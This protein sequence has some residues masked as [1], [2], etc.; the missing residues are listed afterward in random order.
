MRKGKYILVV[1]FIVATCLVQ[2]VPAQ[3]A[4]Y[5]PAHSVLSS[6]VWYKMAF[7]KEGVCKIGV[8]EVP[9]LS[10]VS[11]NS[12]GVYGNGGG[13][14]DQK[15]SPLRPNDLKQ[16]AVSVQDQNG[17]GKMDAGDCILFYAEGADE[18]VYNGTTGCM[19]HRRH[20]YDRYNYYYVTTSSRNAKYIAVGAALSE[21]TATISDYTSVAVHDN[22]L[23]NTNK[24]GQIWVG[25]KMS[26]TSPIC[27]I[28]MT[29]PQVSSGTPLRV[30]A[31]VASP[32]SSGSQFEFAYG[33]S[34]YTV[35]CS[36]N[37]PYVKFSRTYSTSSSNPTFDITYSSATSGATGYLDFIELNATSP[38]VF[39]SGQTDVYNLKHIGDGNA[40]RFGI[41][42]ATSA[43]R[44]WNVVHNDSVV[45]MSLARNGTSASFTDWTEDIGHYV[46]F[47]GSR[48][49][50]PVSINRI[51]NQDIHS[52]RGAELVI[53][54]HPTFVAQAREIA[55]LHLIYDGI[56]SY[57]VTPDLV[58]N[59]FSSGKQDP[60]AIRE[61]LRMLYKRSASGDGTTAPRYLL[62]L[63]CGTYDNKNL[64][65]YNLPQV[66]TCQ[67]EASFT[68]EG[69]SYCTDDLF[70][71]LDDGE[72]GFTS[73]SL[74]V[75]IGR[76]PAHNT[77]EA[78][79]LVEK[80]S[81]YLQRSD[82]PDASI[83]G[84]WRNYITLLADDADPSSPGDT[85]FASSSE[86]MAN[87]INAV[88]PH[89]NIDKIYADS[90]QQQSGAI[91]SF[92]PDVNNALRQ[93]MDY[94]CLLF[95]YIGHGSIEYIGTERYIEHS[96]ITNYSN[97]DQLSLFVT[98]TCSY[99]RFDKIDVASG[100]ELLLNADGGAVG[101][102]TASR[103]IGH[104]ERFNT[105]I[106]LNA[107]SPGNTIGDALRLAKNATSV[108]HSFVLLG[109][110]A[111]RLSVPENRVVVTEINGEAVADGVCDS[112][113]VLSVVTVKGMVVDAD[114]ERIET[115]D[116]VLYPTVFDRPVHTHTLANDN[117][118]TE[119]NFTQQNSIIYR[120]RET[121]RHGQF[122][123]SFIVP[124][125]VSSRYA[126]AKLSHFA[127]TSD[128]DCATG[129]Y[130]QLMLGGFNQDA[131]MTEC[132]PE[133]KLY[134]N[135]T[136]FHSGG[137]TD[138]NPTLFARLS[139][140]VGIN[141]VG[142]GI[143]HN[144]TAVIDGNA[145]SEITLNDFYETDLTDS[146]CGSVVY[147]FSRL[148]PG[149][150]T[151]TLKAWNIYNY[152]SE[153]T[154]AFVVHSSDSALI[155]RCYAYPNPC[156]DRTTLH[157]EHN[158]VSEIET[159]EIDILSSTGQLVRHLEP[160]IVE[161]SYV[162]TAP[163][164]MRSESGFTV[165]NGIYVARVIIRTADGQKSRAHAK[166]AKMR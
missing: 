144:I 155:G 86:N 33:S 64:L 59:E 10:G 58:F 66:L 56:S 74:D 124:R 134:I 76:L 15:N 166:I 141:A 147:G 89:F 75:S 123:Y 37:T 57:V 96:D 55:N 112:A 73:E 135:D 8:S 61:M 22:D 91:G 46:I 107:I 12:I 42:G 7:D 31:A 125:D 160:T 53:V 111:L 150:H 154:I 39:G 84:D 119:V 101:V 156:E 45:E 67:S 40:A 165:S 41:T 60:M 149:S 151:L 153:A 65:A 35:T 146:R 51:D 24:T 118:G 36:E 13:L 109:D 80:I 54:C 152:S 99:G 95:N 26:A 23:V 47:D 145:N 138:E 32:S 63:G 140:K 18:W 92:Y 82:L 5:Y 94:G 105:D 30:R 29:L 142:S 126:K 34:T 27:R 157:I 43:M 97:R 162:I 100:S 6:G 139:D 122:E 98:S 48:Y 25:E 83:R 129:S 93:R 102:I 88:F 62:L 71:Y 115:F 137:V 16:V 2:G 128:G 38:L 49:I 50:S 114:G 70:G 130:D 1:F 103:P 127:K 136:T 104:I 148:S 3:D 110:P 163:W 78:S 106:C 90:Y 164:D 87:R 11:F 79:H 121:V 108:S 85:V 69:P 158:C 52:E 77:T 159:I 17:N 133:I 116:G 44:V 19:E 120:G 113:Q 161:G 14:M 143:G 131:D 21:T 4:Y 68:D 28:S 9:A 72:T 132:R 117:E 81:R 20:P